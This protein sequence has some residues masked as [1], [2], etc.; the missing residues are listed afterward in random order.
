MQIT[1]TRHYIGRGWRVQ[2]REIYA[3]P[4]TNQST[5]KTKYHFN[6]NSAFYTTT[7]KEKKRNLIEMHRSFLN[8]KQSIDEQ[9]RI[10][11]QII[12]TKASTK[13]GLS[14][15]IYKLYIHG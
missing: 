1:L 6:P 3:Q 9:D 10:H 5:H 12:N 7:I 13:A 8:T 15:G 14:F 4:V 2:R 11:G